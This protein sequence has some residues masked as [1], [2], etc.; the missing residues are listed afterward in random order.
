M[1]SAKF[2]AMFYQCQQQ[3]FSVSAHDLQ[4]NPKYTYDVQ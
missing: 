1:L 3:K 2:G 4:K